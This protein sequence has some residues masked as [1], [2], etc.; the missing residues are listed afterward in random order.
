MEAYSGAEVYET[1]GL[2]LTNNLAKLMMKNIIST[3]NPITL[4]KFSNNFLCQSQL[5]YL[6]ITAILKFSIKHLGTFKVS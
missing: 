1:V 6:F 2:F 4:Q 3:Q 5:D